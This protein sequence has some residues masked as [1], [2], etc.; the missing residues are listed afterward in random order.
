MSRQIKNRSAVALQELL[1]R[2]LAVRSFTSE[3]CKPLTPEDCCLQS[4]AAASPV[5]WHLAHTSWF[6]ETFLLTHDPAYRVFDQQY[7][8]L[9]NSYYNAVG[10]QFPREQRGLLSR[11]TLEEVFAYRKHVDQA[12]TDWLA[13]GRG[14]VKIDVLLVVELGLQHEQQHQELMLTDVK[15]L[16]SLNPRLPT[17]RA[18]RDQENLEPAASTEWLTCDEGI[19]VI[20]HAGDRF[21]YDNEG[22]PHRVFLEPSTIAS[23]PVTG[24]EFLEF[25]EDGG[26][27]R[28]ELWLS[29]GWDQVQEHRWSHPLYWIESGRQWQEFTLG[30]PRPLDLQAPVSHVSYFEADSFARWAGGRLPTEAEWEVLAKEL[31]LTGNFADRLLAED[32]ALHP[33][34]DRAAV[35]RPAGQARQMF[36]DVWEWTASP[37]TPYPG[38]RAAAGALGEYNGK[39][40]CNQY[41]LRGGSVAT[42]SS[43][44]RPTYRNF[45]PPEARWQFSGFRLAK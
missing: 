10:Q 7:E 44:I 22:P 37:Y 27:A 5:R 33:S 25:V 28:P 29:L 31:P 38:Y 13:N 11:P 36:G 40:M 18:G 19:Y 30:G 42:S 2:Y 9:F 26:Y 17:F 45:F 21:A 8:V 34:C 43:H 12:V 4:M 16:F 14:E 23:C 1:T 39:F 6:F 41:V 32:H 15:H 24:A 35:S 20:G 3:L